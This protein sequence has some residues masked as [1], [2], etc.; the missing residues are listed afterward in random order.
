[1][2]G[3]G[4]AYTAPNPRSV[5]PVLGMNGE[6]V[7]RP[8]GTRSE[9]SVRSVA[10]SARSTSGQGGSDTDPESMETCSEL[11]IPAPARKRLLRLT[12]G[13]SSSGKSPKVAAT[14]SA[15]RG[16]GR[17]S[18]TGMY[19]GI[20]KAKEALNSQ[21]REALLL[22]SEEGVMRRTKRVE[23]AIPSLESLPASSLNQEIDQ[24][25]EAI[26]EVTKKS[27][28]LKGACIRA[29]KTSAEL[30]R[31]PSAAQSGVLGERREEPPRKPAED[32]GSCP[33]VLAS[34]ASVH[35]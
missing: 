12:S 11:D 35:V 27:G 1:M 26:L 5:V 24:A 18:T 10:R 7:A 21:K 6:R 8:E 25:L 9:T 15:K 34:A 20:A 29:L 31:S 13:G 33:A 23:V 28:N 22:E 2:N 16:R 17:P 14:T 30:L 32:S 19:I 4:W 3:D